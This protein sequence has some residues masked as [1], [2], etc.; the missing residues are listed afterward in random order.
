MAIDLT[1]EATIAI[2]ELDEG[3]FPGHKRVHRSTIHKWATEGINGAVL[4]TIVCGN[5]R[6]TTRE[7]IIRFVEAQ[8]RT[9]LVSA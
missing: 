7:A 5:K 2:D 4:E 6:S 1:K 9:E 3:A 8:N